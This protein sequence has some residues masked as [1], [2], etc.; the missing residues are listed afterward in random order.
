MDD[1]GL[2]VVNQIILTVIAALASMG[3]GALAASLKKRTKQDIAAGNILKAIG[4]KE[5]VDA[6][7]TFVV[8]GRRIT[9]ERFSEVNEIYEAYKALGGNG[10]AKR[11]YEE[12]AAK[13]PWIE[14]GK[15]NL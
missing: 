11:M 8:E 6:Y 9:V 4:R 3:V 14:M 7:Q 1:L 5:I 15:E 2:M 10:T 13:R 12:I